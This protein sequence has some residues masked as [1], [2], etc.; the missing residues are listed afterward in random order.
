MKILNF[1]GKALAWAIVAAI[2]SLCWI[3][4]EWLIEGA[5]HSSK[6]DTCVA[7]VLAYY[8]VRGVDTSSERRDVDAT[9]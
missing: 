7:L 4:A 5:V 6:I 2:I 9:D 1:I 3:G 8:M